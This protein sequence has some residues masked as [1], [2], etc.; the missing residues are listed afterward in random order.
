MALKR[1]DNPVGNQQGADYADENE[2]KE[3]GQ[4]GSNRVSQE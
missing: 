1:N 4:D 2:E 3:G